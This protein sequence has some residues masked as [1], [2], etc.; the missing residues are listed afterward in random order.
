MY[1]NHDYPVGA[2][3]EHAPWNEKRME[4]TLIYGVTIEQV[5]VAT[6]ATVVTDK[7]TKTDGE[8][9]FDSINWDEAAKES[10]MSVTE[11]LGI[12]KNCVEN[13]IKSIE[14]EKTL[15]F[16]GRKFTLETILRNC[17]MWLSPDCGELEV[18]DHPI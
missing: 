4:K 11:L 7:Y 3:N 12:L 8:I 6:N 10:V 5:M 1:N 17:N 9:D 15:V 13:E 16:D 18:T 2:D 14:K